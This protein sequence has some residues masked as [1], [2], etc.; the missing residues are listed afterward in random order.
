MNQTLKPLLAAF[1]LGI[2]LLLPSPALHA[3]NWGHWRGPSLNGSTTE[4]NLPISWS[5]TENILWTTPLPGY[6]GA[7]PAVWG[8]S[9][10]VSSP[11]EN[12]NLLLL[13]LNRRDGKIR[14]QK[15]VGTGDRDV[16][17]NNSTSSSPVTDG[18]SVFVIFA[19]GDVAAF[20]FDGHPLWTR[21]LATDYGRF[22]ILWVYGSSPL[23]HHDKLYIQVLQRNAPDNKPPRESFLLCLDAR[24]GK[25]L[26]RQLRATDAVQESQEAYSSP[27]VSENH[28]HPEIIVAGA[29]FTTA[30]D[31]NTGAELWRCGGLVCHGGGSSRLVPSPVTTDDSVIV[32]A[33]RREAVFAL[34]DGGTGLV[35]DKNIAWT[36]K[37]FGSDCVTPLYYQQKLYVLDGD[38]QMLTCLDPKTGAKKWSGSLGIRD[39]FRASPTG[40]DGKIYCLSETG[41]AV[42]L[43]AGDEFKI[44]ATIPMGEEPVRASIAASHGNLFIRTSQNLYCIGK[45]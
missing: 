37:E 41:T 20:D 30:H 26:W 7:T 6:S 23:L 1:T 44:L 5:K 40:A 45:K 14:W 35:T 42:V 36:S 24:T 34:N 21:N 16:G 27:I 38:K 18:K 28:G 39:I 13:C 32:C 25:N 22:S 8:D 3:E 29:Q 31:P 9:V 10:F 11:D 43:A 19:T 17:R 15:T 12:K 33:P 4:T 2:V